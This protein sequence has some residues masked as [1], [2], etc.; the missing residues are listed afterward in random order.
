MTAKLIKLAVLAERKRCADIVENFNNAEK[1]MDFAPKDL[2]AECPVCWVVEGALEEI[3]KDDDSFYTEYLRLQ[4]KV[5]VYE[6]LLHQINTLASISMNADGLKEIISLICEWS[7][8]HR[9]G[10]GELSSEEQKELIA[11]RF[12]NFRNLR[13]Q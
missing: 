2:L 1:H 11:E 9:Q 3:S 13:K 7:Y 6:T 4:D 10:N 5:K 8:A 12:E